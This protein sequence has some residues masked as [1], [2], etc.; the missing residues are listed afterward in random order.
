[1]VSSDIHALVRGFLEQREIVDTL[2]GKL[3]I[4]EARRVRIR[5]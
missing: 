3:A 2:V 1:M 5:V 4:V